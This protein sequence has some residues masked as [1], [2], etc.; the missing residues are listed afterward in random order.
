M[1]AVLVMPTVTVIDPDR[2]Q[3]CADLYCKYWGAFSQEQR[4]KLTTYL[5]DRYGMY[6]SGVKVALDTETLAVRASEVKR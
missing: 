1:V 6:P 5:C 4:V 3:E 2:R